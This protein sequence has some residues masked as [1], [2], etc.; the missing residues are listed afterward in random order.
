MN[1]Y[2]VLLN[3]QS[4]YLIFELDRCSHF[5]VFKIFMSSLKNSFDFR[6]ISNL[7]F[8]EFVDSSD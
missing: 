8:T 7:V 1:V 4:N 3:M 2:D 6:F 5:D